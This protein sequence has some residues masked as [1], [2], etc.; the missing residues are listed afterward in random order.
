[1]ARRPG[2]EDRPTED[3]IAKEKLGPRGVPGEPDNPVWRSRDTRTRGSNLPT[4]WKATS[5]FRST[6]NQPAQS[7]QAMASKYRRKRRMRV[8]SLATPSP[9]FLLPM[10]WRRGNHS[11]LQLNACEAGCSLFHLK[12]MCA[13]GN[14]AA[15]CTNRRESN[16][17]NVDHS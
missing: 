4:F 14:A 2:E 16:N 9:E 15:L 7:N 6:V 11:H 5:N 17:E 13:L 3:D 1:M 8:V 10:L 12:C